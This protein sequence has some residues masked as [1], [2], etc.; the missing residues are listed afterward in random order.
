[1]HEPQPAEPSVE[2]LFT[3]GDLVIKGTSVEEFAERLAK[4]YARLFGVRESVD[5]CI[6]E[7][8]FGALKAINEYVAGGRTGL[9]LGARIVRRVKDGLV[10]LGSRSEKQQLRIRGVPFVD[11]AV[12][13]EFDIFS[14]LAA[15]PPARSSQGSEPPLPAPHA[16]LAPGRRWGPVA[17]GR[18]TAGT[19]LS[20]HDGGRLHPRVCATKTTTRPTLG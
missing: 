9:P 20:P 11:N 14:R 2:R 4:K 15:V 13:A 16:R 12:S 10:A 8:Q 18:R 5:D 1:M 6:P 19:L 7:A 3:E 17:S